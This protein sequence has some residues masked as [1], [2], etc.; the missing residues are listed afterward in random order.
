MTFPSSP[1]EF[2]PAR[3]VQAQLEQVICRRLRSL[4]FENRGRRNA[5][6][7]RNFAFSDKVEGCL[8]GHPSSLLTPHPRLTRNLHYYYGPKF[9][10]VGLE[11][12]LSC[13][14]FLGFGLALSVGIN[15]SLA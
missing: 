10:W 12:G 4:I 5:A 1:H 9:C 7:Y 3:L 8:N 14:R 6:C 13:F 11:N 2:Q 15:G